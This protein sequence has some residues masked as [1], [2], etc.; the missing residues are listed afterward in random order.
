MKPLYSSFLFTLLI[1]KTIFTS[2]ISAAACRQTVLREDAWTSVSFISIWF[3]CRCPVGVPHRDVSAVWSNIGRTVVTSDVR[4]PIRINQTPPTEP[5]DAQGSCLYWG[6][7][8]Q[9]VYTFKVLRW[10]RRVVISYPLFSCSGSSL[11][12]DAIRALAG[13]Q[14]WSSAERWGRG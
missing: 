10:W 9:S 14:H 1:P 3:K 12:R 13:N 7:D 5:G 11:W 2:L 6:E 8:V 4:P